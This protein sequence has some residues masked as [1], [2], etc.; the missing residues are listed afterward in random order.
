M[1]NLRK[2]VKNSFYCADNAQNDNDLTHLKK[3]QQ[4]QHYVYSIDLILSLYNILI[5]C[6]KYTFPR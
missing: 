1:M 3:K 4:Q 6:L 2:F 5:I